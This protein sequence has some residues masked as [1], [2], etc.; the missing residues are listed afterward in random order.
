MLSDANELP[1]VA[2]TIRALAIYVNLG[3]RNSFKNLKYLL[4]MRLC[5][6]IVYTYT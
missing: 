6:I 3:V 5:L 2:D 1:A 4:A